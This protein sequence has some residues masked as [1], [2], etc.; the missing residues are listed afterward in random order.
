[1]K[2]IHS[3]AEQYVKLALV[4]DNLLGKGTVVDAFYG[5]PSL[6]TDLPNLSLEELIIKFKQLRDW[7]T[8]ENNDDTYLSRIRKV[9]LDRQILSLITRVQLHNRSIK[10]SYS[11][12][13]K[14]LL[15][16]DLP[17]ISSDDIELRHNNL[18][19][20]FNSIGLKGDLRE[21]IADWKTNG[22]ISTEEYL[23]IV[24]KDV[25][26]YMQKTYDKVFVPTLGKKIADRVLKNIS[27]TF[28]VKDS[29]ESW[30]AYNYYEREFKGLITFNK[31]A[32]FNKFDIPIFIAHEV[33]PGHFTN[34]LIREALYTYGSLGP[35]ATLHLLCSSESPIGEGIAEYGYF[36]ITEKESDI[37]TSIAIELDRLHTEAQYLGA[38]Q[39]YIQKQQA[40]EVK[41][42]IERH[43][44]VTLKRAERSFKFLQEWKY[45][46]PCYFA[47]F[48]LIRDI[49]KQHGEKIIPRI[50][51]ICNPT[52][53]S[54]LL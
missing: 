33:F 14:L 10:P 1:M 16:I 50:Y 27:L 36:F 22:V 32:V 17:S 21:L 18:R 24:K 6:A 2:N 53:L 34:A 37:N 31:K 49:I 19:R 47:G 4:T 43:G 23:S 12:A 42:F 46:V 41:Q 39:F 45:Y 11:E 29:E 54:T 13:I 51:S 20:L 40:D 3:V 15:D 38:I 35:E 30:S 26:K 25:S 52:I 5:D 7:L 8:K 9:F 44:L 48:K 28:E